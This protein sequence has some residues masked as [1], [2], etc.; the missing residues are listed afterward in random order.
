MGSRQSGT[1]PGIQ[2]V[3][4]ISHASADDNFVQ[5]LRTQLEESGLSVW[6]DSRKLRGGDKLAPEIEN[7][8]VQA[9][10]VIVVLSQKT[11]NSSWVRREIL[12]RLLLEQ[13]P[14][15]NT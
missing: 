9:R 6:V 7:A 5:K 4:F 10:H 11:I 2:L 14:F 3:T 1:G 8:I 12:L 13:N 15:S